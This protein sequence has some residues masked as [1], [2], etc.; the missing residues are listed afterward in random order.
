MADWIYVAY[1]T[2][3]ITYVTGLT[4][5]IKF[6]AQRRPLRRRL[7]GLHLIMAIFTFVALTSAMALYAYPNP[8][9]PVEVGKN[10]TM[11]DYVIQH[12]TEPHWHGIVP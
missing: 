5:Y 4:F 10:S 2:Y 9:V 12:R 6:D 8:K 1:I 7:L 3:L 11:W